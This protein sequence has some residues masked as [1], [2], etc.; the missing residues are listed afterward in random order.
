MGNIIYN[1]NMIWISY[2]VSWLMVIPWM[3]YAMLASLWP[4]TEQNNYKLLD[5]ARWV[6]TIW[7]IVPMF[8]MLHHCI[9][10]GLFCHHDNAEDEKENQKNRD[11]CYFFFWI[12]DLGFGA[13]E[14]VLAVLGTIKLINAEPGYSTWFWASVIMMNIF[15]WLHFVMYLGCCCM[16]VGLS[17]CFTGNS[18]MKSGTWSERLM[19]NDR[20]YKMLNMFHPASNKNAKYRQDV[21]MTVDRY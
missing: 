8:W 1:R 12:L 14:C 11:N 15:C 7:V 5:W 18:K 6:L 4:T 19:A 16:V 17:C 10:D 20:H 21:G 13:V 9:V 2:V 3:V